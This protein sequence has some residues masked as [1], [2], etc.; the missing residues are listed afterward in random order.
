MISQGEAVRA[1]AE[2]K[3]IRSADTE[4]VLDH[5][6]LWSRPVESSSVWT[7]MRCLEDIEGISKHYKLTFAEAY[8]MMR[9]KG[10]VIE[11]RGDLNHCFFIEEDHGKVA[12]RKKS[13]RDDEAPGKPAFFGP[14]ALDDMWRVTG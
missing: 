8:R 7:R 10:C 1:L 14:E 13:V 6:M 11:R 4:Y 12:I 9:Y 5:D 3:V 2:G